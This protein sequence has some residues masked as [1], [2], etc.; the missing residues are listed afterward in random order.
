MMKNI[1]G[2]S[3]I[4]SLLLILTSQNLAAA[5]ADVQL[6]TRPA[7]DA[8][9]NVTGERLLARDVTFGQPVWCGNS[10][11]VL[12]STEFGPVIL[13]LSTGRKRKI[14][15]SPY[16]SAT[17]CSPDGKWLILVDTRTGR[18]DYL[19]FNL[20]TGK[21]ELFAIGYGG[22]WSPDGTKVLFTAK[23]LGSQKSIKQPVPQWEFYWAHEWPAGTGGTQAWLADSQGLILGH[24]GKFY[25][26]RGQNIAPL[27]L[28]SQLSPDNMTLRI[29]RMVVD[30]QNS[31][32]VE[33]GI[34]TTKSFLHRLFKCAF[35]RNQINCKGITNATE[36]V[37]SFD[38]SR[39]GNKLVYAE[40]SDKCLNQINF[41]VGETRCIAKGVVG[42]VGISPDA[43]SVIFFRFRE[44][45]DGGV[46]TNDAYITQ[47]K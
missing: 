16:V 32:Y 42:N 9:T 37:V 40:D 5:T 13:D 26:Q 43:K 41:G 30:D 12:Q 29:N 24:K 1:R 20:V 23:S 46:V 7:P 31:L 17:S 6:Q 15:N 8:G 18:Q 47:L 39:D 4:I 22:I 28:V 2:M 19:R 25:L 45:D 35:N 14:A 34:T 3:I 36:G 33:A 21:K 10:N 38:V 44:T 11:L 27:D